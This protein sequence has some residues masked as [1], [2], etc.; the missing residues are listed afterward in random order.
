M[1]TPAQALHNLN[2]AVAAMRLTREEHAVL[3]QSVQVLQM[4]IDTHEE[5]GDTT[6]ME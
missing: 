5:H 3:V 6:S 4:V 2:I 1:I